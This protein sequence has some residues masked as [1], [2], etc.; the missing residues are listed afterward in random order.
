M[1]APEKLAEPGSTGAA[2]AQNDASTA[3]C[4]R[5]DVDKTQKPG[6]ATA[7]AQAPPAQGASPQAAGPQL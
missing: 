6:A 1:A 2:N 4:G 3:F 5:V 7:S